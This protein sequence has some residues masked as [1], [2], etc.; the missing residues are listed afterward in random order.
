MLKLHKLFLNA[1]HA[2]SFDEPTPLQL[3]YAGHCC[4]RLCQDIRTLVDQHST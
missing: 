1:G 2:L 3:E 4:L